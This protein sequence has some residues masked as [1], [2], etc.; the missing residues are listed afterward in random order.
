[1]KLNIIIEVKDSRDSV[2][3]KNKFSPFSCCSC[4]RE[5]VHGI[6]ICPMGNLKPEYTDYSRGRYAL[7]RVL[8]FLFSCVRQI[9]INFSKLSAFISKYLAT[10]F[11]Q[12]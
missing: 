2:Q 1:M 4:S 11:L 6:C 9:T 12:P 7:S 3:Q 8:C 5:K 10:L